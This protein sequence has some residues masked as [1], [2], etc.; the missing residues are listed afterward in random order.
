M[1]GLWVAARIQLTTT[2]RLLLVWVGLLAVLIVTTTMSISDLYDTPEKVSGYAQAARSGTALEAIN[3]HVY[4]IDSLG[5]VIANEFGF[6]ASF[7]LP[8]MAISL[9]ARLTKQEEAAGRLD[10]LLAGRIGRSA[11]LGAALLLTCVGLVATSA[12]LLVGLWAAGV[13]AGPSLLY[14]LSIAGVGLVFA[15]VA[16]VCGQLVAY[17]RGIYGISLAVL[18][19][20]Y[21]LRGAGAVL[22]NA[23]TWFSPLGWAEEV[24]AFGQPRWWPLLIFLGAAIL[25]IGAAVVVDRARDLGQA[26]WHRGTAAPKAAAFLRTPV[27]FALR[28]HRSS[29]LGWAAAAVLVSAAFGSL[30]D[31]ATEALSGNEGLQDVLGGQRGH[32]GFLAIMVLLL[33]VMYAACGVQSA[34]SLGTEAA[35]GRLELLLSGTASRRR[36]LMTHAVVILLGVLLVTGLGTTALGGAA[37]WS[38]G[39]SDVL[40]DLLLATASYLPALLV[41]AA[42]A[43]VLFAAL[44]RL[45]GL[46]WL[47]LA[48][49]GVVALL[50]DLLS[51]PAWIMDLTP[52]HHVGFPPQRSAEVQPLIL[53]SALGLGLL[54][55]A[56][57]VFRHRDVARR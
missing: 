46:A 47:L 11:P 51:L 28:L 20:G 6:I 54:V 49:T 33:A 24:R 35:S 29:F 52:M 48:L 9:I 21:V 16:V 39:D 3:G 22:N 57:A 23:M 36:W 19:V 15:G 18:G 53:L 12:A 1:T 30:T 5:G 26:R 2:W 55:V 45:F 4:G 17:P 25:L 34:A 40:G 43:I 38:L 37:A 56:V 8:L 14:A 10:L 27:G 50:G 7:A 44:P 31:V 41:L 32:S 42:V 13:D